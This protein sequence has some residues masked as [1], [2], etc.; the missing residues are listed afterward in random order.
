MTDNSTNL[1]INKLEIY[2]KENYRW[3]QFYPVNVNTN[4]I[5]EQKIEELPN[6]VMGK[7]IGG[8]VGYTP[9]WYFIT[10]DKRNLREIVG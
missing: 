5:Y 8:I 1:S 9:V 4:E 10:L 3:T 7:Y 6:E 2:D